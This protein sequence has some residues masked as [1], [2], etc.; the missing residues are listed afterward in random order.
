MQH[1]D[2]NQSNEIKFKD[3]ADNIKKHGQTV[4][5]PNL[6]SFEEE[7]LKRTQSSEVTSTKALEK[8]SETKSLKLVELSNDLSESTGTSSEIEAKGIVT[9]T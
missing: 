6:K 7:K 1:S 2:S 4:E 8:S 5:T 3:E 9:L